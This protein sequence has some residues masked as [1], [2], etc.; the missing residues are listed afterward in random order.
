MNYSTDQKRTSK[1][2]PV[3][4]PGASTNEESRFR[5]RF[6]RYF[7]DLTGIVCFAIALMTLIGLF[8]PSLSAG[9]LSWWINQLQYLFGWGI[10][11]MVLLFF[12]LGVWSVR[13]QM[14]VPDTISWRKV[15]TWEMIAIAT[16]GV[17][18]VFNGHSLIRAEAGLD[19]GIVGWGLVKICGIWLTPLGS[20]AN[21]IVGIFLMVFLIW[22]VTYTTGLWRF[23][24]PDTSARSNDHGMVQDSID[25][26]ISISPL[27]GL[28]Q[29]N[30]LKKSQ[31]KKTTG[32]TLPPEFRKK[33]K[34]DPISQEKS[35]TPIIRDE[36]LP[37]L[38]LLVSEQVNRQDE[39]SINLTAGLIEKTLAEFGIPAQ[40]VG[41]KVGPTVTQFAIEPGFLEK[42]K[43][44]SE[45]D[46][47]VGKKPTTQKEIARQKVR[48]AQIAS[49]QKDLALAL[50]AERLRIE[51]PVPGRPY[52]GIEVPNSRTMAVRLKPI[53]ES[54]AFMKIASPLA[55]ALGRDVSGQPVV[56]DL[57]QMPH[58]MVAGTT[59]SGKSVCLS[60]ITVCLVMNNFPEDLRLI[61]V[62]P[63][64]VELQR[65]KGLPHILG[66]IESD[67]ERILVVL[68][69]T[70]V[71]MERRYKLLEAS[72][73]RN[74]D[75]Y[76]RKVRQR[77]KDHPIPRIVVIIDELAELMMS[78]PDETE[79]NIIRLAQMARA[80][81]IHLVLAT[82][83]PST[84]VVT[85]LIKANFPARIAFNVAS[86][87]DSRV[88]LDT[89]GAETLLGKGDMLFLPP[90]I[91][92][93]LR[94]QGV[95]VTDPEIQRVI[96]FWQKMAEATGQE[97]TSPWE[98]MIT[99]GEVVADR[100]QLVQ[101]AIEI[102]RGSQRASTSM[103]QRR[104]RIGYPRAAR[105]MEELEEL[106]IVGASQGGG[107]DR[108]VLV[109]RT[110]ETEEGE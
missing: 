77:G 99:Q 62:D 75:N 100:D 108:D 61:L 69:W 25:R 56:A 10:I 81:G 103:L 64:R 23:I 7:Y 59:G 72:H 88:I 14:E 4:H 28:L 63:K 19:G 55:I 101:K 24:R 48:V 41:F 35:T 9:L 11:W 16:L 2:D 38:D 97:T 95:M 32:Q 68:R 93:P 36:K 79:H 33:L 84:N 45:H 82:Q 13:R 96:Q 76:N 22:G 20:M 87:V 21:I 39:R 90:D 51:A 53:L 70:V 15:F 80:V 50:A 105:L 17:F 46:G 65:F 44:G 85:G 29:T 6:Q 86:S 102:V 8:S 31:V 40:V 89:V 60:A 66:E 1:N 98:E 52:V 34:A 73:S 83:R 47:E 30:L 12:V 49:L 5:L 78:A 74:I 94:S 71:E 109:D 18:S 3:I 110:D 37:G 54:E 27:P 43:N 106:G 92:A 107:R 67:I 42:E 58:L 104:L 26:D 57:S 91:S